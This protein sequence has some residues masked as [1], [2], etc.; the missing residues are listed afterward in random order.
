MCSTCGAG[1]GSYTKDEPADA[2]GMT[3][4]GSQ[5]GLL[6]RAKKQDI[7]NQVDSKQTGRVRVAKHAKGDP[8]VQEL[9]RAGP[10]WERPRRC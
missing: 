8:S 5:T 1:N 7:F 4:E 6:S 10:R 2:C 3:T 9:D